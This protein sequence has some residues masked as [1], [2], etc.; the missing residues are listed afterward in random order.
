M[1]RSTRGP[2]GLSAATKNETVWE[3]ML[4]LLNE[5]R[6]MQKPQLAASGVQSQRINFKDPINASA[7]AA[8][9]PAPEKQAPSEAAPAK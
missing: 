5:I 1:H 8:K 2:S 6:R 9:T 4:V 7:R 3:A